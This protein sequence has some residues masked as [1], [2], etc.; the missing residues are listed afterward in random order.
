[1]SADDA[2]PIGLALVGLGKIARDQHLPALAADP[3]FRLL[4]TVDPHS[5]G[6]PGVPH[7]A[8]FEAMLA[9]TGGL[10]AAAI[11]TPPQARHDIARTAIAAGLAVL[12]EK[13]PCATVSEA[14]ALVDLAAAR[15]T[16]LFAAWH[17]RYAATVPAAREWLAG[18]TV[19]SAAIVWR[20]DVRHWHPGQPWI[21]QA[22]GFGVFDPGI[23]ALSIATEILPA[24]LRVLGGT[25]AVPANCAAPVAGE[26]ALADGQGAEIALELDFLQTGPQTWDI[27][28]TTD[29]GEL[30]LSEGGA[31]L[32]YPGPPI[33][34]DNAEYPAIYARFAELIAAGAE[35]VF[36]VSG[37]TGAGIPEL[38]DAVLGYLPASTSTET[39]AEEI[40]DEGDAPAWSPL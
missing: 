14:Q 37:A 1:M 20:E 12:L 30:V 36:A 13:P 26:V 40:E 4:A 31:K 33:D 16:T 9:A 8:T 39:K 25:L 22:G 32:R 7:F 17:S 2:A 27:R 19:R 5:A 29:A 38:L 21:W 15:G 23:N 24:P 11:C 18:Q 35:Q 28:V 3:R 34:Q 6:I 10:D